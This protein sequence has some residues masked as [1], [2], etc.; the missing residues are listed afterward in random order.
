[1]HFKLFLF[2]QTLKLKMTISLTSSEAKA[3][4]NYD[5]SLE[6]DAIS[7]MSDN[8]PLNSDDEDP[9]APF[10]EGYGED[11]ETDPDEET[12]KEKKRKEKLSE[13]EDE[14]DEEEDEDE[15]E[16]GSDDDDNGSDDDDSD[17]S[18]GGGRET[19]TPMTG[20]PTQATKIGGMQP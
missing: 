12:D 10:E 8:S 14:D 15:D 3:I 9:Y 11:E 20:I 7:K 5:A 19:M 13:D 2:I 6:D 17:D 1:M 18:G 16:D 4:D